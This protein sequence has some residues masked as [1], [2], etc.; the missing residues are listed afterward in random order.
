[1][2]YY[3][4]SICFEI[5]NDHIYINDCCHNEIEFNYHINIYKKNFCRFL[6]IMKKCRNK[7]CYSKHINNEIVKS[8]N[9]NK[10]NYN[11]NIINNII[12]NETDIDEGIIK[13]RKITKIWQEKKEIRFKEIIELYNYIF[14]FENRYL[15]KKKIN[16][17]KQ[18]FVIF[19]KWNDDIKPKNNKMAKLN[20]TNK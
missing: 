6:K 8:D 10:E 15:S 5:L 2:N 3:D 9:D 11:I 17:I 13:F 12:N 18:N 16:E 1:M 19:Q 20:E 7:F 4:D 14:S